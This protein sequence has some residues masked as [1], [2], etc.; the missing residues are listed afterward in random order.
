MSQIRSIRHSKVPINPCNNIK[1]VVNYGAD[2]TSKQVGPL[3]IDVI[4]LNFKDSFIDMTQY[5]YLLLLVINSLLA[6]MNPRM[7]D[8]FQLTH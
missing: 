2:L 5:R 6:F 7:S 8:V 1:T 4:I 3:S